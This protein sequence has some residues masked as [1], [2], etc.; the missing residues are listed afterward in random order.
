MTSHLQAI[1]DFDLR[2]LFQTRSIQSFQLRGAHQWL[3][4]Q[5]QIPILRLL[6]DVIDMGDMPDGDFGYKLERREFISLSRHPV[7]CELTGLTREWIESTANRRTLKDLGHCVGQQMTGQILNGSGE[8]D[9]VFGIRNICG[10]RSGTYAAE[11]RGNV[12]I[13]SAAT[14]VVHSMEGA[15]DMRGGA[16]IVSNSLYNVASNTSRDPGSGRFTVENSA[17]LDTPALPAS[18]R[19]DEFI[20]GEWTEC[21]VGIWDRIDVEVIHDTTADRMNLRIAVHWD[22]AVQYPAAFVL[23]NQA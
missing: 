4:G 2:S 8:Q 20:Y 19:E 9:Q 10:V 12:K 1:T 5:V 13:F 7:Y 23:M 21:K 3:V 17:I 22:M 16:Y 15:P 14:S 11:D 6:G 18:L